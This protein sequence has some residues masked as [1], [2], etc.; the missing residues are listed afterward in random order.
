[1]E[2]KIILL[3]EFRKQKNNFLCLILSKT[4]SYWRCTFNIL[5]FFLFNP[6]ISFNK[7]TL[8]KVT[9]NKFG[10]RYLIYLL[11]LLNITR[12]ELNKKELLNTSDF[13]FLSNNVKGLQSS[14]KLSFFKTRLV[15]KVSCFYKKLIL[16]KSRKKY[17]VMNLMVTYFFHMGK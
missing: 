4:L 6:H 9:F 12:E 14:K 13:N 15:T 11:L 7:V 10:L 16:R 5:I 8:N 2:K 17:G 3:V 1:M